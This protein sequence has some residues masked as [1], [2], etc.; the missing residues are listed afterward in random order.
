MQT[1]SATLCM[2]VCHV[3]CPLV[4]HSV[5]CYQCDVIMP[6]CNILGEFDPVFTLFKLFSHFYL[7]W[8]LNIPVA[9]GLNRQSV[10]SYSQRASVEVFAIYHSQNAMPK[11]NQNLICKHLITFRNKQYLP[12]SNHLPPCLSAWR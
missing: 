2:F 7:I 4:C 6:T 12:I 9:A 5:T 10:R 3:H 8:F 11:S 1:T